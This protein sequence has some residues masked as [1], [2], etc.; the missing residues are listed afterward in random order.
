MSVTLPPW[1]KVVE[2]DGVM[3]GFG[4]TG[5]IEVLTGAESTLWQ[6]LALVTLT[7]KVTSVVSVLVC[8]VTPSDHR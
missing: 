2:P 6:P 3:T 8:V 5:K 1:Q 7:V 4:G